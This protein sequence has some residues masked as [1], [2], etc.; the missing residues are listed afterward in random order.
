MDDGAFDCA[1]AA[2]AAALATE[3]EE[4][5]V[6][7]VGVGEVGIGNTTASAAVLAMLLSFDD[8][9]KKE[10]EGGRSG[11]PGDCCGRGTGVDDGRQRL[12]LAQ[13]N[14]HA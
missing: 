7:V 9:N 10:G 4:R 3:V 5:G 1:L 2:G 13:L 11:D 12:S 8:E 6:R 14:R